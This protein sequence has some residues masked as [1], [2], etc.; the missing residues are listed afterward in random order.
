MSYKI[1]FS[2]TAENDLN[3]KLQYILEDSQSKSIAGSY[4]EKVEKAINGLAEFP[5]MAP[6][7][8]YRA[9]REKIIRVLPIGKLLVFYKVDEKNELI[10]IIRLIDGRQEY[11]QIL[12]MSELTED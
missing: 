6:I 4:L 3:E 12:K 8:G 7:S 5:K 9:L 11:L 10:Y 1:R 2:E